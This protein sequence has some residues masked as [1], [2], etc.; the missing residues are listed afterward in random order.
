VATRRHCRPQ[1]RRRPHRNF[2]RWTEEIRAA[3]DVGKGLVDGNS[4]DKGSEIVEHFDGGIAQPLVVLEMAADKDEVRTEVARLPSRHPA[5]NSEGPRL[6]R[7]R[8]HDPPPTAMGLPRKD[9]LS[10]CSTEA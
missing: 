3:G 1:E 6:V 4:L 8:K 9:G 5:T 10:S 7:S 2:G